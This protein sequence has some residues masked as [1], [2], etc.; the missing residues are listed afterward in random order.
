MYDY[1]FAFD[2]VFYHCRFAISLS[3]DGKDLTMLY[4]RS[5]YSSAEAFLGAYNNQTDFGKLND[6]DTGIILIHVK[7]PAL[8]TN[9][10]YQDGYNAGYDIGYNAGF[11][12][13]SDS[14]NS[15]IGILFS[16]V[17][18]VLSIKL[19]G[20]VTLGLIVY[21]ALGLGALFV[22]MKMFSK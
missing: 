9:I 14:S 18:S 13:G 16:G 19:F 22:V 1:N 6:N 15:P 10:G 21:S 17:N 8:E 7:N 3:N 2:G 12:A 20:D 4:N 5:F 11:D